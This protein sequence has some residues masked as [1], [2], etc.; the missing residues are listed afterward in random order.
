[1]YSLDIHERKLDEIAL[2]ARNAHLEARDVPVVRRLLRA[3]I[4]GSNRGE[5]EQR[6]N[7]SVGP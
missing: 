3:L 1:V 6:P 5:Q 7:S 4:G 2:E